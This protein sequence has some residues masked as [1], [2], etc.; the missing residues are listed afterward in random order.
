MGGTCSTYWG[1]ERFIQGS[2]GET[3]ESGHLEDP[4]VDGRI[5]LRWIFR[6]WDVR[7]WTGSSW[8]RI[9]TDGGHL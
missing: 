8:L 1:E 4:V 3:R 7:V 2:G 6:K 5:K 9:E